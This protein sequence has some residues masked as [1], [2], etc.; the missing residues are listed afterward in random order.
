M[1]ITRKA[2]EKFRDYPISIINFAEGTR[3]TRTKRDRQDSP[4]RNLLRPKAGGVGFVLSAMGEQLSYIL[5][6]TIKYPLRAP[7][8]WDFLCGRVKRIDV[9]VKKIPITP[10]LLGDYVMDE[11]YRIRF[12]EW[13]NERWREKDML[14]EGWM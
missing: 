8:F 7:N 5:D 11:D 2:C 10:D 1:E 12:Q 13:L 14:L 4:F 6:I 3:F 9:H